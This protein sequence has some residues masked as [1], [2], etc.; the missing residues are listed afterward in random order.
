[1]LQK[2]TTKKLIFILKKAKD[3][4]AKTLNE[5][6]L[7]YVTELITKYDKQRSENQIKDLAKKNQIAQLQITK[8]RTLWIIAFGLFTLIAVVVFSIDKQNM[9]ENEKKALSLKQDAL[10]SQMNPHFMFNALNSNKL[11][12]IKNKKKI[13]NFLLK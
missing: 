13:Y 6:N 1:M 12:I 10:R 2:K 3:E 7:A 11:Y 5:R 9:L 4:D 8:N